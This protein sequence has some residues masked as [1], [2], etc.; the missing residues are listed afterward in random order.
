MVQILLG[1][2]GR[3]LLGMLRALRVLRVLSRRLLLPLPGGVRAARGGLP[4][5]PALLLLLMV[6]GNALLQVQAS[7]RHL[8]STWAGVATLSYSVPQQM[9]HGFSCQEHHR[10][11]GCKTAVELSLRQVN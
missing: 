6:L 11:L 4:G 10:G 8:G 7:A 3:R 2:D 5:L 1:R 9:L